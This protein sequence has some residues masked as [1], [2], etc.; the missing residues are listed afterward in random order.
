MK[1]LSRGV[2]DG[3]SDLEADLF[4]GSLRARGKRGRSD[5]H[6]YFSV[7]SRYASES[8]ARREYS[9]MT[10]SYSTGPPSLS[11][12]FPVDV[13]DTERRSTSTNPVAPFT[14]PPPSG[15]GAT[16]GRTNARPGSSSKF[17][18]PSADWP[19]SAVR[20][21]IRAIAGASEGRAGRMYRLSLAVAVASAECDIVEQVGGNSNA[22]ENR[23]ASRDMSN[24]VSLR[25]LLRLQISKLLG[26][27]Q[28]TDISCATFI[29]SNEL[30]PHRGQISTSVHAPPTRAQSSRARAL[31]LRSN[32]VCRTGLD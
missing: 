21:A 15:K 20:N 32:R 10:S 19:E 9:A 29:C 8:A 13:E 16:Y 25:S 27:C 23:T 31:S 17:I 14:L 4:S 1:N 18:F 7:A 3:D 12:S 28:N 6:Q 22:N 11:A 5:G 26:D 24:S 30:S 2:D